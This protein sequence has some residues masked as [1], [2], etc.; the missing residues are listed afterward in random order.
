MESNS[1]RIENTIADGSSL[2][3][4]AIEQQPQALLNPL[5]PLEIQSSIEALLFISDKPIS[6]DKLHNLMGP[7]IDR[8]CFEQAIRDLIQRYQATQHGIEL[9]EIAGGYQLRTKAIRAT[10]AQKLVKTQTQ[11]L[12]AGAMET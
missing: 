4:D 8:S 1:D 11:R 7:E 9:A 2:V 12:S 6:I 10:L 3:E 5:D